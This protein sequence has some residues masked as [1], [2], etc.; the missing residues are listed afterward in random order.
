MIS[1]KEKSAFHPGF[2]IR[3]AIEDMGITQ[4]E[5][6]IRCGLTPKNAS[7]LLSGE[8][9]VTFDVALKLASFFGN[10]VEG[11]MN[12]QTR[13]DIA[14]QESKIAEQYKED[15]E[16]AKKIDKG[17]SQDFLG[18]EINAKDKNTTID[19][20]RRSLN[21]G[22]LGALKNPDLYAFCK[23]SSLRNLDDD[24]IVLR[25]IW[26]T[27]AERKAKARGCAPFSKDK[28]LEAIPY[29]RGL[30]RKG[31]EVFDKEL[32]DCLS[33]A[34]IKLVILPYLK[35][36]LI[37]GVTKWNPQQECVI[38]AI[39]AYG[40]D[41][42]RIWFSL[43]HELGHAVKNHKRHLTISYM[44]EEL[45]DKDE[46][47]ADQFA[48]DALINPKDYAAFIKNRSF[49]LNS[50]ERFAQKEGVADFVVIG[51]LQHDGYLSWSAYKERKPQYEVC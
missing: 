1:Q 32:E 21:V 6:A 38:L 8:S 40:G 26:I 33:A 14:I 41:A 27:T 11:W 9:N 44:K 16:I 17:F 25:N 23:T 42:D 19:K 46:D 48:K 18:V 30:T 28:L 7:T 3:E 37:S 31:P 4:N 51:R 20:L 13:Y 5:F 45:H 29:L 24:A 34:G 39:N 10:S 12:L 47:E 49:D 36:S 2:Y 35:K 22:F 43:F 50:I 15:W